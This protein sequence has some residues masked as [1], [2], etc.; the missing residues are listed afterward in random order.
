M[1]IQG[2][3]TAEKRLYFTLNIQ[4]IFVPRPVVGLEQGKVTIIN[5]I[6]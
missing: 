1:S 6:F 4:T 5:K 3:F 2:S